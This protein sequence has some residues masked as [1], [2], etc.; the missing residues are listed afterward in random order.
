MPLASAP[1]VVDAPMLPF[2]THHMDGCLGTE[3]AMLGAVVRGAGGQVLKE[4]IG[5]GLRRWPDRWWPSAGGRCR[6][7]AVAPG[8]APG[9]VGRPSPGGL[10]VLPA[11]VGHS[12]TLR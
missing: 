4:T 10:E 7:W 9:P 6:W 2:G 3:S 12:A 11:G 8:S 1:V 5:V